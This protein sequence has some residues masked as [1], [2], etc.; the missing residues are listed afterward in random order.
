MNND[1]EKMQ[2]M[3]RKQSAKNKIPLDVYQ[4]K[5]K[6]YSSL[7][8]YTALIVKTLNLQ[9]RSMASNICQVC[10][11]IVLILFLLLIQLY[12][13]YVILTKS[14]VTVEFPT[15]YVPP[16]V[17][18]LNLDF[19]AIT[20]QLI[21]P[22]ALGGSASRQ[23][24]F[25]NGTGL[26]DALPSPNLVDVTFVTEIY[27]QNTDYLNFTDPLLADATF[28][29]PY[30]LVEQ[31]SIATLESLLLS[32]WGISPA[33]YSFGYEFSQISVDSPPVRLWSLF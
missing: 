4:K 19:S 16:A 23:Q 17:I 15:A 7:Q 13:D 21:V 22:Y 2:R 26:L 29:L 8:Q 18:T 5:N 9:K 6:G 32:Q 3:K 24:F 10:T 33:A 31:P 25:N 20:P 12:I 14:T 28:S 1:E 30:G 11:P 27:Q